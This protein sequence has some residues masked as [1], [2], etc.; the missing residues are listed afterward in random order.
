MAGIHAPCRNQ[1]SDNRKHDQIQSFPEKSH[2]R[3]SALQHFSCIK[4]Q[5]YLQKDQT[6]N[7][8]VLRAIEIGQINLSDLRREKEIHTAENHICTDT[9]KRPASLVPRQQ[10]IPQHE[11]SKQKH[12]NSE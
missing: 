9:V 6:H 3:A 12:Q 1:N 2:D 10:R 11:Q 4:H 5:R 7:A 8:D